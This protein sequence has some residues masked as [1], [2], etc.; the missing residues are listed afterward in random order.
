MQEVWGEKLGTVSQVEPEI[1]P[2][3]QPCHKR[4]TCLE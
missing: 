4:Q 2:L 3:N 1:V